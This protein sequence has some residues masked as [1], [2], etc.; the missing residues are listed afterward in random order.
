MVCSIQ[1]IFQKAEASL[2]VLMQKHRFYEKLAFQ[3]NDEKCCSFEKVFGTENE[4]SSA[5][6]AAFKADCPEEHLCVLQFFSDCS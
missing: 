5:E 1:S 3:K 6:Q 2:P 4:K